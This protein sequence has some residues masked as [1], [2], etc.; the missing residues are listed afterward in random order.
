MLG[1]ERKR[2]GSHLLTRDSMTRRYVVAE[3]SVAALSSADLAGTTMQS[4]FLSMAIFLCQSI[5]VSSVTPRETPKDRVWDGMVYNFGHRWE[6]R[7]YAYDPETGKAENEL[8]S[9]YQ[10]EFPDGGRTGFGTWR[11]WN[12]IKDGDTRVVPLSRE[13][14]IDRTS[15]SSTFQFAK[16]GVG[17]GGRCPVEFPV[18]DGALEAIL[19]DE[20]NRL[21]PQRKFI[22]INFFHG[23][24]RRGVV[25]TYVLEKEK[26]C[27]RRNSCI[28]VMNFRRASSGYRDDEEMEVESM[29]IST[30]EKE[31]AAIPTSGGGAAGFYSSLTLKRSF[32]LSRE[33]YLEHETRTIT[34]ENIFNVEN[35]EEGYVFTTYPEG[36][37]LC[38]PDSISL[39]EEEPPR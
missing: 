14:C 24:I 9:V 23:A 31:A 16:A 22:E 12:V 33:D 4:V 3:R 30:V 17:A 15:G 6:G 39:E 35:Q 37:F 10:L 8:R 20:D 2:A 19:E 13:T 36:L 27:Y 1:A 38:L 29:G 5:Q 26:R 21:L 7:T 11:G 34:K 25:V 28:M 18:A 32:D